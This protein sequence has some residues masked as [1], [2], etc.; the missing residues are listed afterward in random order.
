MEQTDFG[1]Y[2]RNLRESQRFSLKKA[3]ELSE[4]S[5]TYI[6]QSEKGTRAPSAE[7]LK[8]LATTYSVNL[9]LLLEAA[10]YLEKHE[11]TIS[12]TE[13]LMHAYKLVESDP[14]FKFGTR[15]AEKELT[16]DVM[17]FIIEVYEKTTGK[18]LL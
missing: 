11:T 13:R 9:N 16:P 14:K 4:L 12:E 17:R 3:A 6:W 5:T 8:K 7:A 18:K 15:L 2:L 1:K 10:G